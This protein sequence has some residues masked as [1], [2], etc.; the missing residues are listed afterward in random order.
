MDIFTDRQRS[1][2]SMMTRGSR[3][4]GAAP[5]RATATPAMDIFTAPTAAWQSMMTR[6]SNVAGAA[7]MESATKLGPL[8]APEGGMTHSCSGCANGEP[9]SSCG[10]NVAKSHPSY[11]ALSWGMLTTESE[12]SPGARVAKVADCVKRAGHGCS[13]PEWTAMRNFVDG[14]V[15]TVFGV[16][17]RSGRVRMISVQQAPPPPPPPPPA[18]PPGGS[19]PTPT[20]PPRRRRIWCPGVDRPPDGWPRFM[21]GGELEL[22]IEENPS[23]AA[24]SVGFI[25]HSE[26]VFRDD[27]PWICECCEY[28]QF[29]TAHSSHTGPLCVG[30]GTD[31]GSDTYGEEDCIWVIEYLD[32]PGVQYEISGTRHHPDLRKEELGKV[33]VVKGPLCYGNRHYRKPDDRIPSAPTQPPDSGYGPPEGAA[34]SCD[35]IGHDKPNA[36]LRPNCHVEFDITLTGKIVPQAFCGG[37]GISKTVQASLSADADANGNLVPGS[38]HVN[39][40]RPGEKI[41]FTLPGRRRR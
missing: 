40:S 27:M 23:P 21:C 38:L 36:K 13:S 29:V 37:E 9:C 41:T 19:A 4:A 20:S 24:H 26:A 17:P 5:R 16:P 39:I 15:R 14:G 32:A 31:A 28:A 7:L 1:W 10:G 33:I 30:R 34:N 3:V 11:Q 6:L 25:L 2:A 35:Y 8:Y 18:S 12:S 22:W